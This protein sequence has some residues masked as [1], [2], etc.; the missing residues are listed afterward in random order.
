MLW[1][2]THNHGQLTSVPVKFNISFQTLAQKY[3]HLCSFHEY[4]CS[5]SIIH[6]PSFIRVKGCEKRARKNCSAVYVRGFMVGLYLMLLFHFSRLHTSSCSAQRSTEV[7][8]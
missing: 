4:M 1:S 3:V 6:Y 2:L 8:P 5:I 7:D